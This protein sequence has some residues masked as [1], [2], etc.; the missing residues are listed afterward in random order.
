MPKKS[1]VVKYYKFCQC[2]GWG[3]KWT[4][5]QIKEKWRKSCS[6]AKLEASDVKESAIRPAGTTWRI[7]T[8]RPRKIIL[9]H[10]DAP[11]FFGIDGGIDI[12]AGKMFPDAQDSTMKNDVITTVTSTEVNASV[13]H[14]SVIS[15]KGNGG[16]YNEIS[17]NYK[18]IKS[19]PKIGNSILNEYDDVTKSMSDDERDELTEYLCTFK[20]INP[21]AFDVPSMIHNTI[22]YI[23]NYSSI[24]GITKSC[25]K[26][27]ESKTQE[28]H[29]VEDD[30]LVN[31]TRYEKEK[32]LRI[33][34]SNV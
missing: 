7:L 23:I 31:M 15:K 29:V 21:T 24:K 12:S 9:L 8:T 18:H 4:V 33:T 6:K 1:S 11:H 28:I 19:L 26:L 25:E 5:D 2:Q 30:S 3:P 34:R 22:A 32:L 14:Y 13:G 17:E 10:E 27:T 20:E 16:R